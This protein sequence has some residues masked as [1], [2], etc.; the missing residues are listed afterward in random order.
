M[1]DTTLRNIAE[2]LREIADGVE[3]GRFGLLPRRRSARLDPMADQHAASIAA[4]LRGRTE[5][6]GDDI[7]R[8]IW[9]KPADRGLA[10]RIGHYMKRVGGWYKVR[11]G[12]GWRYRRAVAP[13]PEEALP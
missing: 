2:A 13:A 9:K 11:T 12:G 8:A 10:V 1:R 4:Y 5:V 3:K 6:S 7:A